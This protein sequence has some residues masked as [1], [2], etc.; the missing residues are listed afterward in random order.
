MFQARVIALEKENQQLILE[1]E[2]ALRAISKQKTIHTRELLRKTEEITRLKAEIDR[3]KR[4][5]QNQDAE[6]RKLKSE[7]EEEKNYRDS[8]YRQLMGLI[9]DLKAKHERAINDLKARHSK[10]IDELFNKRF[11]G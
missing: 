2:S 5:I 9:N 10:E 1:K 6:I 8:E 4:T 11:K 3:Q 7:A